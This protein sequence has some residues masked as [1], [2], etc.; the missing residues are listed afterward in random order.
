MSKQQLM[1]ELCSEIRVCRKCRLWIN[2]NKA[3]LGEGNLNASIMFIGEAPDYTEDL[4]GR[5]SVGRAGK[6]LDSARTDAS[7]IQLSSTLPVPTN[8]TNKIKNLN[9]DSL[10]R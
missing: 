5:P 4:E 6:V 10:T 3:V 9:I 8:F 1:D 7:T 2:A